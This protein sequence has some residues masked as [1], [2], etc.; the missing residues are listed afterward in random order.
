MEWGLARK[1]NSSAAFAIAIL[2]PQTSDI[3]GKL[4]L[5]ECASENRDVPAF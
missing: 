2:T 3:F 1:D 4:L 5:R